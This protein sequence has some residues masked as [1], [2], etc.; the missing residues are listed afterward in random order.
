MKKRSDR[1]KYLYDGTFARMEIGKLFFL[2]LGARFYFL[3]TCTF[4]T[5]LTEIK[6]SYVHRSNYS[7]YRI[8][9]RVF[10]R[11]TFRNIMEHGVDRSERRIC[12]G[13]AT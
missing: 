8:T 11:L 2:R 1:I 13:F 10:E 6:H 3:K 9:V 7:R 4:L 12:F 5:L